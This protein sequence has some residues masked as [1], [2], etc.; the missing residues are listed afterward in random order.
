MLRKTLSK[1]QLQQDVAL[2]DNAY[3]YVRTYD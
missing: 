2:F 1:H 3:G